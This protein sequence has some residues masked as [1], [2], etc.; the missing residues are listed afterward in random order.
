VSRDFHPLAIVDYG[1]GNL[2]SLQRACEHV[3]LKVAITNSKETILGAPGVILPGVG[4]FGDAMRTLHRLDLVPVLRDVASEGT[5][6]LGVCL[7]MQLLMSESQEFGHHRG[8]GLVDGEVVRLSEGSDSGQH[9]KVPHIGWS[10]INYP[11][12]ATDGSL[13]D[14][15]WKGSFLEDLADG[16]PMY[17]VHSYYVRPASTDV[18][19]STTRYASVEF[20]SSLSKGSIFGCQFHPERSGPMGLAVYRRLATIIGAAQEKH[21]YD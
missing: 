11:P 10:P 9:L 17:F 18:V 19:L 3:G 4:A 21:V 15:S 7:G 14:R 8:L 12:H 16:T 2:Y 5:P 13:Q 20:C 6:I 1:M